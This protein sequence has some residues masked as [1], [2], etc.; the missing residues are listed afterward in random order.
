MPG[1]VALRCVAGLRLL[2]DR[3]GLA[4]V[5]LVVKGESGGGPYKSSRFSIADVLSMMCSLLLWVVVS[6]L[7][8]SGISLYGPL[9]ADVD[10]WVR[11]CAVM[12]DRRMSF[13]LCSWQFVG[14]SLLS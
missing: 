14:F 6:C 2:M 5:L 4:R 9:A 12:V 1:L 3:C 11:L 13:L 10:S 8:F 7:H